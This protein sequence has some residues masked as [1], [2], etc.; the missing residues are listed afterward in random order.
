MH[1]VHH[2]SVSIARRPDEVYAFAS[3]P[4]NLSRWAAGL[5]RSEV[6]KD[7]DHWVADA[8]F[9]RIQLRFAPQNSYGIMDHD[10]TLESGSTIHNA[11]RVVPNGQGSELVFTVIRQPGMSDAQLAADRAAVERDLETLKDL[12]E[13]DASLGRAVH[14]STTGAPKLRVQS[15]GVSIDGYGAGP[16]QD[17]EHPL[18]VRGPELM[19]WAFHTRVFWTMHGQ[20]DGETG[21]DNAMA[22]QGF[23]NVGAWILGRNMF[24]PVRGPWPDESWKGW[25]GDEPPYHTPVFV[26]T[27]HARAPLKMAGGTEFRFVT[28]GIHAGLEQAKAAA[29][30][31][32]V[33]L[34]GG[35]ATIR[36]YLS[37]G[38]IDE[39]HLAISPVLLGSGEHLLSGIDTRALGYDCVQHV[40]GERAIHVVLRKR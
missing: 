37:A 18:G 9:G 28:K 26:L 11:M 1:D 36:Q 3:D 33:R 17:L 32:D 12:L 24:G 23:T 6:R 15:F 35:V 31:R 25:W 40:A 7:G 19:E 5:A 10:V 39:L 2:V 4:T 38:L 34:G 14:R 30:G 22:E 27:H 13:R 21:V 20:G 29:G 16:N 8:P